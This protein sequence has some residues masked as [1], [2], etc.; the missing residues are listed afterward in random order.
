MSSHSKICQWI[1]ICRRKVCK[2]PDQ[3]NYLVSND[4]IEKTGFQP[5]YT[6]DLG[7][8]EMVRL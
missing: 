3:R 4:K 5:Q 6:L 2:D 1:Y 7:I 8:E